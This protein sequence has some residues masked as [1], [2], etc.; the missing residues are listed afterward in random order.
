MNVPR[1]PTRETMSH[2]SSLR[3]SRV[4]SCGARHHDAAGSKYAFGRA[5]QADQHPEPGLQVR[6]VL[7]QNS[8][9][10]PSHRRRTPRWQSWRD[11]GRTRRPRLG[12]GCHR[13]CP[14]GRVRR[15]FLPG[16]TSKYGLRLKIQLL[17]L[18]KSG[19]IASAP[20]DACRKSRRNSELFVL[21]ASSK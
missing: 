6:E 8:R 21:L 11:K 3:S 9:P 19:S 13:G 10:G 16:Q 4:L 7:P 14:T 5:A 15:R 12:R 17:G 1:R 2:A 20:Q 18:E